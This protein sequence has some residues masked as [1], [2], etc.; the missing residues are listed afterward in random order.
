MKK[1]SV[2]ITDEEGQEIAEKTVEGERSL[3]RYLSS[4][5]VDRSDCMAASSVKDGD[6]ESV[7]GGSLLFTVT[8]D[9]SSDNGND[10]IGEHAFDVYSITD[11]NVQTKISFG[12]DSLASD[13]SER[14]VNDSDSV[15]AG[16]IE[17]G[18]ERSFALTDP[19][20]R[21]VVVRNLTDEEIESMKEKDGKFSSDL[22][23]FMSVNESSNI[24]E[25]RME[26]VYKGFRIRAEKLDYG[27]NEFSI[28][29]PD[30]RWIETCHGYGDE[31]KAMK[32]AKDAIDNSEQF[33]TQMDMTDLS[34]CMT[35]S[36]EF[37]YCQKKVKV[38]IK[39]G[40]VTAT[41][42]PC[43]GR[44]LKEGKEECELSYGPFDTREAAEEFS[45]FAVDSGICEGDERNMCT[46][47]FSG[48]VAGKAQEAIGDDPFLAHN[49]K[50]V[51][52]NVLAFCCE[53][54]DDTMMD[55][56]KSQLSSYGIGEDEYTVGF[57]SSGP[58][59]N[60]SKESCMKILFFDGSEAGKAKEELK[61]EPLEWKD[62]TQF[63]KDEYGV[64]GMATFKDDD[65]AEYESTLREKLEGAGIRK[66]SVSEYRMPSPPNLVQV[67][68]C[69]KCKYF[70]NYGSN[71]N[72]TK[73]K[74]GDVNRLTVCDAFEA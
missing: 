74:S 70:E 39:D 49:T 71:G 55:D 47:T 21:T 11:E 63:D 45:K 41:I 34:E 26:E 53:G 23:V 25:S 16:E 73:Y 35:E 64:F 51:S 28:S 8:T 54:E 68:C 20:N 46:I 7:I 5:G 42:G 37:N 18:E 38:T 13:L 69:A 61:D 29:A 15:E 32:D 10:T 60:E 62:V 17:D 40:K 66:W 31:K 67:K 58:N 33:R 2:S 50:W 59:L 72:C 30:G 24:G 52:S 43:I 3:R 14:G 1:F 56:V 27:R 48:K 19:V 6:A 36:S 22:M 57:E 9:A 12:K 65:D 4:K 44:T